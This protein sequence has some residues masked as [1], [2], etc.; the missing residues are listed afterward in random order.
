MKTYAEM[1]TESRRLTIL[2]LLVKNGGQVSEHNLHTALATMLGFPLTSRDDVRNDLDWLKE[3]RLLFVEQL[4]EGNDEVMMLAKVSRSG[5]DA[6][7][8][9][10]A[11]IDG[12]ARPTIAG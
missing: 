2:Q 3:R 7:A 6:A 11:P 9:R 12:L 1:T 4:P 5:V 10:G 8:G